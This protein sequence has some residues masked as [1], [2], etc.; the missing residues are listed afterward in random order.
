MNL[1]SAEEC[2]DLGSELDANSSIEICT[3]KKKPFPDSLKFQ[4]S[5]DGKF[6]ENGKVKN[7]LGIKSEKYN[8]YIGGTDSCQGNLEYT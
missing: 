1:L 3:G 7:R 6:S 8:F 2:D 5:T 4:M